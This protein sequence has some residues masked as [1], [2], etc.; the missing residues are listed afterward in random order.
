MGWE[1]QIFKQTF[2]MILWIPFFGQLPKNAQTKE[3]GTSERWHKL[4]H[5]NLLQLSQNKCWDSVCSIA[6]QSQHVYIRVSVQICGHFKDDEPVAVSH[7]P[8][9]S[10][11]NGSSRKQ[12]NI[13][14]EVSKNERFTW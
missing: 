12:Y 1:Y 2:E 14:K 5:D 11:E 13:L 10:R 6:V 9:S 4:I 7:G 8:I 3:P